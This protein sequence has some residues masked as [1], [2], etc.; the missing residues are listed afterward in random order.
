ME[1]KKKKVWKKRVKKQNHKLG[2]DLTITSNV[3]IALTG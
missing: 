2:Q 3:I 1:K